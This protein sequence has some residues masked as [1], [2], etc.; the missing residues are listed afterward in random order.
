MTVPEILRCNLSGVIL[1]L[2]ALGIQDMSQV[3]FIDRP[4][5]KSLMA[6]FQ[7][8]IKLEAVDPTTAGLTQ[9]GYDMSIMPT[10]PIYSKLLVKS[11]KPQFK[12]ISHSIAAIVAMLSVENVFYTM[13]NLDSKNPH[14]K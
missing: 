2:K 4:D 12:P 10:D 13:T 7:T 6:A 11:L 8:L 3:D 9:T 1:S 14:D 5:L